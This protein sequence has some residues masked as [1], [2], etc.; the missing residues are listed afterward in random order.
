MKYRI[1]KWTVSCT[2]NS[3]NFQAQN[4]VIIRM[5]SSWRIVA[6]CVLGHWYC[7]HSYVTSSLMTWKIVECTFSKF[8]DNTKLEEC[9]VEEPLGKNSPPYL[10][11]MR[12]NLL[13]SISGKKDLGGPGGQKADHVPSVCPCDKERQQPNGLHLMKY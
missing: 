2:G 12:T 8:A 4:I 6:S 1:D 9:L 13:E 11:R 3:P 7:I 10:C 5:S